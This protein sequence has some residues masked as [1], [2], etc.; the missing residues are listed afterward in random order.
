MCVGVTVN[1]S[2][3][4]YV[5]SSTQTV[6][7]MGMGFGTQMS[8]SPMVIMW[9]NSDGTITVSQRQ[10]SGHSEPQVVSNPPRVA[11]LAESASTTSG[12]ET[13]FAFTVDANGDTTE[14]VIYAFGSTNPGSS[15]ASA[16]ILQHIDDGTFQLNLEGTLSATSTGSASS[17]D[18][19]SGTTRPAS[20]SIPLQPYQRMIIAHAILCVIGFLFFLPF[21]SLLA[22]YFRTFTPKWYTGH[23][24][25][26]FAISGPLIIIGFAL[27][28]QSVTT[29]GS[30]HLDDDH[31]QWGVAIFALYWVQCALGAFIHWVKPKRSTGR[32]LQNY[33]H[34]IFGLFI[35]SLAFYQV[36][37]GY[38]TEWPMTTGRGDIANGANVIWYIWVV[39]VPLLY[40]AGLAFL[41]KQYRQEAAA[42]G[43]TNR[44][45]YEFDMSD[46]QHRYRN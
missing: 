32:P 36:R 45:Q 5:L 29:S 21:G 9:S 35:I 3:V 42:R 43:R 17:P 24:I 34:A 39:V 23:W 14:N 2:S 16:N 30:L 1:G 33:F 6:G 44:L 25:S 19:T 10:A 15:S 11:T 18:S 22:R 41:P 13:R 27:G 4:Q 7:W 31:K 28:V 20:L 37:T 38:K 46:V 8:G 40:L 12:S 26:Q